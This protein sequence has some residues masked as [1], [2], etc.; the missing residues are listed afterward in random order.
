MI[1][2]ACTRDPLRF[3]L[4]VSILTFHTLV[5]SYTCMYSHHT[6]SYTQVIG[7]A[8]E[9]DHSGVVRWEELGEEPLKDA[10]ISTY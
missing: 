10:V 6:Y 5:H 9:L 8:Q 1:Y 2:L 3:I 4:R 7:L